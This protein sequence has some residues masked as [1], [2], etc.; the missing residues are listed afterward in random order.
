R[1]ILGAAD[2]AAGRVEHDDEARQVFA[3]AAQAIVDPRA[4]AW[5]AGE[6]AARV[7]L[8]HGRAMDR[9]V[10]GHRVEESD[11]G[12]ANRQVREQVGD[13]LAA[14]TILLELPLR[15]DDAPLV[16]VAAATV[17]LH[18]DRLPIQLIEL[19]LVVERIDLAGAAVHEQEDDALR[20]ATEVW[21][22]RGE[23]VS[24][25][26]R[27]CAIGEETVLRQQ[28]AQGQAGE[29]SAGLP[30]KLAARAAAERAAGFV[31]SRHD[32]SPSFFLHPASCKY[33]HPV[34][35]SRRLPRRGS[36]SQP[37]VV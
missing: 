27:I 18:G 15:T 21:L 24:G 36:T 11:I 1:P 8:E 26:T 13:P 14:L 19:G 28:A 31:G 34:V 2:G 33:N 30:Q 23:R 4:E 17:R 9:R 20:L 25:Y 5:A 10:G 22:L 32:S 37:R 16:L 6:D 7:H 12:H 35:R 29:P 3:D